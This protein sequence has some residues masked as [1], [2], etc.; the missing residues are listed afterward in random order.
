MDDRLLKFA[1]LY[2]EALSIRETPMPK[3][4]GAPKPRPLPEARPMPEARPRALPEARPRPL[5]EARVPA[6]EQPHVDRLPKIDR[7]GKPIK[8]QTP[9]GW[10]NMK[11]QER[12]QL[13]EQARAQQAKR[14]SQQLKREFT[15]VKRKLNSRIRKVKSRAAGAYERVLT[16]LQT[17]RNRPL[18]TK[19]VQRGLGVAAAVSVLYLL[20][21]AGAAPAAAHPDTVA[22]SQAAASTVQPGSG[23]LTVAS[24]L[25]PQVKAG[26]ADNQQAA[27]A[28]QM[29][30]VLL[31]AIQPVIAYQLNLDDKSSVSGFTSVV[32]AAEE[33]VTAFVNR[34][35]ELEPIM[36]SV[37]DLYS[38]LRDSLFSWLLDIES[39][40]SVMEQPAT[41]V[42]AANKADRI[43]EV[44]TIYEH[45]VKQAML[46]IYFGIAFVN[47]YLREWKNSA[48]EA[49]QIKQHLQKLVD[50]VNLQEKSQNGFGQY[51]AAFTKFRDSA[52]TVIAL[53]DQMLRGPAN[54]Q[55]T[56]QIDASN[57]FITS[58]NE[59]LY[60]ANDV[61][62]ALDEL[63]T[64]T[65]NLGGA[66]HALNLDLGINWNRYQAFRQ[67]FENIQQPL[68]LLVIRVGDAL[69]KAQ[70]E[71]QAAE[72]Q[73]AQQA[74]QQPAQQGTSPAAQLADIVL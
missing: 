40:R 5:P 71:A 22:V 27:G 8:G 61:L 7:S 4:R 42:T 24:Q 49:S 69:K 74:Q 62:G 1:E 45:Q 48:A 25:I 54:N 60:G 55:D 64:W 67:N 58:A 37:S 43:L 11:P 70:E 52:N 50:F 32:Q 39:T 18:Q 56:T 9:P 10:E 65:S 31:S 26:L 29:L 36:A 3:M 30:D 35:E 2:A 16:N 73:Q 51:A 23:S 12:A 63:Q 21:G 34:D 14:R 57:K 68:S 33:A 19:V 44:A 20:S 13:T 15:K 47:S 72:A 38:Q 59:V 6:I 66:M 28:V 41:E 46:G 17:L 53:L